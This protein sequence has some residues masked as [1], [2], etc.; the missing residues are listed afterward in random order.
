MDLKIKKH[1][2]SSI[3]LWVWLL[4][5]FALTV[6]RY[7][8]AKLGFYDGLIREFVLT[9]V[10]SIPLICFFFNMGRLKR[11]NYTSF[12]FLY[13]LIL[14]TLGVTLIFHPEYKY[15]F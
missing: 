9:V 1:S 4:D 5:I 15:F 6:M 11:R 2:I 7:F 13:I 8:L 14:I 3:L 10:A 12:F